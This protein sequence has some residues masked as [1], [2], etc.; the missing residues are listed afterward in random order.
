MY[1]LQIKGRFIWWVISTEITKSESAHLF[2]ML[3]LILVFLSLL[4]LASTHYKLVQSE[5]VLLSYF[6]FMCL[7]YTYTDPVPP[8]FPNIGYLTSTYNIYKGNPYSTNGFDP[9]FTAHNIFQ[10]TYLKVQHNRK[11]PLLN[12]R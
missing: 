5:H 6:Y 1:A 9:S 7:L 3:D 10:F 8:R 2:K 12:T 11:W 4:T